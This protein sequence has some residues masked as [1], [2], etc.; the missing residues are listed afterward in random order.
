MDLSTL[1]PIKDAATYQIRHPVTNEPLVATPS[2]KDGKGEPVT[3][4]LLSAD[5]D[6]FKSR[7]F[8]ALNKR[9]RTGKKPKLN[10]E[11]IDEE[12]LDLIAACITGWRNIE[13]DGK[14]YPFSADNAKALLRRL[15]WLREQL[16]EAIADRANFIRTSRTS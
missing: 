14:P 2:S 3:I 15:P 16:D 5:S 4:D 13:L 8:A 9:L 6:A 11:D 12:A 1:E 10:A 7:Q